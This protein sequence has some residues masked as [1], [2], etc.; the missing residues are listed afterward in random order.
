MK[1]IISILLVILML[2]AFVGCGATKI[3]HC[4]K[5]G[6]EV[7]VEADSNMT[8]DWMILCNKCESE[9]AAENPDITVTV[10]E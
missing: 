6:A 9:A 1:K 4:D 7:E 2:V 10:A 3:L 8:E 5:C